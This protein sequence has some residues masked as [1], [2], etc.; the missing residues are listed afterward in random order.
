MDN[1]LQIKRAFVNEGRERKAG[2]ITIT[3][4][5][6]NCWT[7][8]MK[9]R[10]RFFSLHKWNG[11]CHRSRYP[12]QTSRS[13]IIYHH[14]LHV[15]VPSMKQQAKA[16]W[17][18]FPSITIIIRFTSLNAAM[19]FQFNA[20]LLSLIFRSYKHYTTRFHW[21]RKWFFFL[22]VLCRV[23]LIK[24]LLRHWMDCLKVKGW[25]R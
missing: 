3:E 9:R 17:D 12:K 10:K 20:A 15:I 21:Q 2:L 4:T 18:F 24:N 8:V 16:P 19:N 5:V 11:N 22:P 6:E 14:P 23:K 7:F 13:S 1:S 25:H